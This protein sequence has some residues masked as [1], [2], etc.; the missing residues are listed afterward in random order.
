MSG[1][2]Q[3]NIL[4]I[5][6]GHFMD[7]FRLFVLEDFPMGSMKIFQETADAAWK[8][9]ADIWRDFIPGISLAEVTLRYT[10]PA[11]GGNATRFLLEKCLRVPKESIAALGRPLGG[12]GMRLVSPVLVTSPT[13]QSLPPLVSADFDVNVETLLEDPSRLYI[14]VTAKW[15]SLPL[16]SARGPVQGAED[17]PAFLNPKCK[18]PS[19]YLKQ[20]EDLTNIQIEGFLT[21][22]RGTS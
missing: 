16:P 7:K 3:P 21:K 13:Q 2:A 9:F 18:E 1:G 15:P 14:Q 6:I 20:V 8:V 10:A 17:M 19:W 12:V 11:E 22:A 4:R 5:S